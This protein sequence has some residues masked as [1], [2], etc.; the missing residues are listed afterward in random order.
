[1]VDRNV[2]YNFSKKNCLSPSNKTIREVDMKYLIAWLVGVP[3]GIL[4]I[5]WFVRHIIF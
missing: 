4:A 2:I 5:V 1:M 3:A